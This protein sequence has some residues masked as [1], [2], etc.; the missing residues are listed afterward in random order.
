MRTTWDKLLHHVATI[1]GH[2]IKYELQNKNTVIIPKPDH[3]QDVLDEHQF[4][5]KRRDQSYQCLAEA[6]KFQNKVLENKTIDGETTIS[7]NS[8]TILA[9]LNNETVEAE[10]KILPILPIVLDGDSKICHEN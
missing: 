2:N 3:N 7:A 1:H 9:V 10:Y 8:K 6:R 5:T 4:T